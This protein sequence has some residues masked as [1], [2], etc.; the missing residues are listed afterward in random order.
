MNQR[1]NTYS[2]HFSGTKH[3]K[4]LIVLAVLL[5]FALHSTG[6]TLISGIV[7]DYQKVTQVNYTANSVTV[8]SASA[9]NISDKVILIQ[10]QGASIDASQSSSF[11]N[12]TAYNDAG[13]Y[14]VQTVCDIQGNDIVFAYD[15]L[16]TYNPNA[17]V[18]LVR[19]PIYV[20]A[21]INGGDLTAKAWDGNT[22]GILAIDVLSQ[23][24]FS[25]RNIDVRG[26]G[27]RGASLNIASGNCSWI[28]D[29]SYYKTISSSDDRAEKGEGISIWVSGKECGRGP[30]ANGG[31]GGN[32]HNGG[33]GGGSNYGA[34]GRGGERKKST[35]FTCGSYYGLTS[36]S[37]ASGYINDKIFMGGGGGAGHVNNSGHNGEN[38]TNGAGIVIINANTIK[39]QGKNIL[40][41]GGA[42]T[43]TAIN[44]G[45]GGGGAGGT[46]L[47][48]ANNYIGTLNIDV[49]GANGAS[50]HNTGSSNCNGPGGGGGGGI[51]MHN[52]SSPPAGVSVNVGGGLNGT[53]LTE[54][55]S[56]CSVGN[57]NYATPGNIGTIAHNVLIKT[58]TINSTV[59]SFSPLPIELSYFDASIK[60]N[61]KVKLEWVTQSE[62]NNQYFEVERSTD[63]NSWTVIDELPGA[64]NSNTQLEYITY[65]NS[66]LNGISYYRLKQV[67]YNGTFTYSDI[68]QINFIGI[69][70]INLF[71]NPSP[72]IIHLTLNATDNSKAIVQ[73]YSVNGKIVYNRQIELQQGF[74][75]YSI[76]FNYLPAGMYIFKIQIPERNYLYQTKLNL[77][78]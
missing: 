25:T 6:Q 3:A 14:E 31:G 12:I 7:N 78:N 55:Q 29:N 76:D 72:G 40:A 19:V 17:S 58:A 26:K 46:V 33:G 73:L 47:I 57:T 49:S 37:L 30:Q 53:I 2:F 5:F 11:G 67:D 61:T 45:G 43:G 70:V 44:D 24:N 34:G 66:P 10:M 28:L 39:G 35:S 36:K 18:Q 52:G 64:G 4:L 41:S 74:M 32:N 27:F 75:Q 20:N 69:E 8:N 65:D 68:E 62:T 51:A 38:G 21:N 16:N 71:P 77:I 22:G 1:A 23:F 42:P 50:V 15:M 54:S 63:R 13:N 60:E 59:C 56:N 48:N 9:F